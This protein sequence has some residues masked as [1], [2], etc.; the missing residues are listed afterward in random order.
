MIV[1]ARSLAFILGL[2]ALLGAAV[3]AWAETSFQGKTVTIYIGYGPGGGYDIYAR[4]LARYL[5]KHLPGNPTVVPRNSPGAG[6]MLLANQVA[7]T[8]PKDGTAIATLGNSLYLDQL[9]GAANIKFDASKFTWIGRFTGL[10][11]LLVSW[12]TSDV[13]TAEDMF[14]HELVV[15]VPG[16]GSYSYLLLN[17][18]KKIMGANLKLVSGYTSG[19][20]TRLAMERGEVEATASIQ[21]TLMREQQ[22]DWIETKKVNLL[23][24]LGLKSYAD[25]PQVPLIADL[26]KTDEQRQIIS[27]FLAPAEIGRAFVAPPDLPPDIAQ[28]LRSAFLA[29]TRDPQLIAEAKKQSLELDVMDGAE[30]QSIIDQISK[31]PPS[32]LEKAKRAAAITVEAK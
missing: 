17:A 11:L 22:K 5:P 20:A 15:G 32:V 2:F 8:L 31:I 14:K 13:K 9:L 1:N 28:T 30:L 7:S 4:V 19:Q 26:A 12:E 3:P 18:I 10:P 27:V 16:A 24:Q 21:W 6:S 29:V 23:A 25:L